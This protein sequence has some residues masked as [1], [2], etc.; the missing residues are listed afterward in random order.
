MIDNHTTVNNFGAFK[1][2]YEL[3]PKEIDGFF[4]P[5][6]NPGKLPETWK[7]GTNIVLYKVKGGNLY[8][9]SDAWRR[10]GYKIESQFI[11]DLN[12][13]GVFAKTPLGG[14]A[15]GEFRNTGE[16]EILLLVEPVNYPVPLYFKAITPNEA[17]EMKGTLSMI[18]DCEVTIVS[19]KFEG[20]IKA[21]K[22]PA[23]KRLFD[24]FKALDKK[25]KQNYCLLALFGFVP[26]FISICGF[27]TN[28]TWPIP[29]FS[30]LYVILLYVIIKQ[31]V[32]RNS[33]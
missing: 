16:S 27:W 7:D 5:Y 30:I 9:H 6:E 8:F 29:I 19:S 10:Y 32:K 1:K 4:V 20:M 11:E 13:D 28:L 2:L 12:N 22:I 24:G 15:L 23:F 14:I 18:F 25:H 26:I 31:N 17:A 33:I 21:A 3:V